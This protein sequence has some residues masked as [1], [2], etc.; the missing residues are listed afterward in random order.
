MIFHTP[1]GKNNIKMNKAEL[2][3][4]IEELVPKH[5]LLLDEFIEIDEDMDLF[6]FENN[7]SEAHARHVINTGKLIREK[8]YNKN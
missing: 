8:R 4:W 6:C 3:K 1:R 7:C 2:Q 5:E